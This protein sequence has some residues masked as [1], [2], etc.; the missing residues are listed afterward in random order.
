[1]TLHNDKDPPLQFLSAVALLLQLT[2]DRHLRGATPKRIPRPGGL[3]AAVQPRS[4][5]EDIES[6]KQSVAAA[7]PIDE[8]SMKPHPAC[9]T[10]KY[11][12][13]VH[14]LPQAVNISLNCDMNGRDMY[15]V[16]AKSTNDLVAQVC[17]I[18]AAQ[19]SDV[20]VGR[21]T[22]CDAA[23]PHAGVPMAPLAE[24]HEPSTK[25]QIDDTHQEF[26]LSTAV[27]GWIRLP[28]PNRDFGF[29][30]S[31]ILQHSDPVGNTLP[32]DVGGLF[33]MGPIL[34]AYFRKAYRSSVC[35]SADGGPLAVAGNEH[36]AECRS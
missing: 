12:F 34:G 30:L 26:G 35:Y 27:H 32:R 24:Y 28:K 33:P 2:N 10:S 14:G 11:I 22:S 3:S 1:M 15:R 8:K 9:K 18:I 29:F 25:L 19:R 17:W 6:G 31:M 36:L 4:L 16:G 21:V 20:V 7:A 23:A 5:D 13:N